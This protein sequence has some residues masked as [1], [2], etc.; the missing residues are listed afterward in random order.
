MKPP[1]IRFVVTTGFAVML[2]C[3]SNVALSGDPERYWEDDDHVHDR[4][5]RAV[6]RGE[7][8]PIAELME[9]LKTRVPGQVVGVEFEREHGKWIYEFKV[10][11]DTGRLVEVY[12]DAQ[13]GTVL[14]MEE[15]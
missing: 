11:D 5:R 3:G 7:T 15:D 8:L 12:V 4:A 9:R 2:A 14:S 1:F 6:E 13:S 10:I